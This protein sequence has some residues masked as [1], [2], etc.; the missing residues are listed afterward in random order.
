M[1]GFDRKN[2]MLKIIDFVEFLEEQCKVPV[3]SYAADQKVIGTLRDLEHINDYID[4]ADEYKR[5]IFIIATN[6]VGNYYLKKWKDAYAPFP[7]NIDQIRLD[8][9]K[10]VAIYS[11]V[12]IGQNVTFEPNAVIGATG[13]GFADD[14]TGTRW[15]MPQMGG[16]YI[17]NNCFIG[18]NVTI[19]QGTLRPTRIQNNVRI[20]HGTQI[21]HNVM[22]KDNTF[23]ANGVSIAGSAFIGEN[24]YIGA[25]A[26]IRNKVRLANNTLVGCG[27]VIIEDILDEKC[28]VV[29]NPGRIIRKEKK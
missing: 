10:Y 5:L 20:A 3:K 26:T 7:G 1:D 28:T 27:A 18:A 2:G 29:G 9:P 19:C 23:I 11:T 12:F 4:V 13:Q 21:G 24:C 22:I 8:I 16:V 6:K 17:G 15:I 14:P 25:G